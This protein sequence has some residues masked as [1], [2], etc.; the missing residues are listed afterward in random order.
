MTA[1]RE[2]RSSSGPAAAAHR[3]ARS[4]LTLL[5]HAPVALLILAALIGAA[6]GGAIILFRESISLLQAGLY[7]S[8]SPYLTLIAG[9]LPWWTVVFAPVAG[10]LAVGLATRYLLPFQRPHGVADVMEAA[11]F[12][13]GR[14]ALRNG[15]AAA[16][17][18]A[19][20]IASGASVGREGPAVHLGGALGGWL[21]ARL[22]LP[23]HS[24]RTLL[25]GGVAAA[26]AASFNVPIAGALFA[27]EVILG[28]FAPSTLA[29]IVVASVLG[30]IVSRSWFG[31]NPA[32]A[33][34]EH[35]ALSVWELPAFL[36]LGVLAGLVALAFVRAV[37]LARRAAGAMRLPL[38]LRP[39]VA[40]AAVGLIALEFPE[41]LGVGYGVT[42][43][44]LGAIWPAQLLIVICVLKLAATAL[45]LGF[46]FG[47]GVFSPSLVVGAT[48]G[49]A[50][51]VLASGL[52]PGISLGS[53][54]YAIVGMGVVA[55]N[56]LGAPI[57][58]TLIVFEMTGDYA[59][60][61][62]V[63]LA[64]VTGAEVNRRCGGTS[65][66]H[67]QLTG[68]GFDPVEALGA[69]AAQS[70]RV[71][72]MVSNRGELVG[73]AVAL[74]ALRRMLQHSQSGRLF[75]I[76]D[77]GRLI[78]TITLAELHDAAF[79]PL[80]DPLIVAADVARRD[81]P[82]LTLDDDL[83]TALHLFRSSG[84]GLI[85]VVEDEESRIFA[86]CLDRGAALLTVNRTLLDTWRLERF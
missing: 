62:V 41:I 78:G 11:N 86:G 48:L 33:V 63:M 84:T 9:G 47:G 32:F 85:A 71:A 64:V 74:P 49:G 43:A 15:V 28:H 25:A 24:G 72:D 30:T 20:S 54:A 82:L 73:T 65:F 67:C 2:A 36:I 19:G 10:G 79:D 35:S 13:N 16:A 21:A 31:D 7:G 77:A 39:A 17:V 38:W 50:F 8:D 58:T 83:Q 27:G 40:G 70:V 76:D 29:P 45:C 59:L 56:V 46:G 51:G 53:D 68:R 80:L 75:V 3:W 69:R 60:T 81:T 44:A 34:V 1:T 37:D 52:L 22:D 26:V 12:G 4:L 6:T 23:G 55:A 61:M 66:F 42:E 57:S 18:S 5:R 14:M